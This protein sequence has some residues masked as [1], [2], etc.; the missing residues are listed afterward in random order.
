MEPPFEPRRFRSAAPYYLDG[1]PPYAALLVRRVAELCALSRAHAVLDLGCGPGQLAVAFAPLA[2]SA[3]AVDPEPE[4]LRLAAENAARAGVEVRLIQGSSF[5]LDLQL[6]P[7][8]LVTIGRAFHWMD[9]ARTLE[10]LDRMIEPDGAVALFATDHPAVPDNAWQ[11]SF[12]ALL[13]RYSEGQS[14]RNAHRAPGALKH[15]AILL[16]SAFNRLERIS[17]IERR[18]TPLERFV[19]RALSFSRTSRDKIGAKSDELARE[20]RD[21][22][23]SFAMDGLVTEVVASAALI[24][25]RREPTGAG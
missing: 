21:A 24:A 2:G 3:T 6:G 8:H 25:R 14:A 23:V 20:V 9:R 16:E 10:Q 1:R 17:V 18:R 5:D 12:E 15:E 22:M 13:D 4:M 7:F 11:D 19:D